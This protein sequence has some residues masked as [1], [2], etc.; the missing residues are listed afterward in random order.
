VPEIGPGDVL[1]R[2]RAAALNRYDWHVA[3]GDPLLARLVSR[4]EV[5]LGWPRS[6]LVGLDVA[7]GAAAVAPGVGAPR[8]GDGVR[9]RGRGRLCA[10]HT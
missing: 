2:V 9:I 5:G 3:R 8:V 1:L 10:G 7:G 6:R 4:R